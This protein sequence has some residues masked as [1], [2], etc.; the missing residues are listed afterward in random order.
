MVKEVRESYLFTRSYTKRSR[1]HLRRCCVDCQVHAGRGGGSEIVLS[2]LSK[3]EKSPK[4]IVNAESILPKEVVAV[5]LNDVSSLAVNQEVIVMIK[6]R[7]LDPL[8]HVKGR[9]G[10]LKKQDCVVGDVEGCCRVVL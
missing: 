5:G 6:V 1:F 9:D 2:R 10:R 4:K 3:E 7:D 8:E